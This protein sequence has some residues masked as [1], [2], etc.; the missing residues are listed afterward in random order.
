MEHAHHLYSQSS[1]VPPLH[2]SH[3]NLKLNLDPLAGHHP[4]HPRI[5]SETT[6]PATPHPRRTPPT[7]RSVQQATAN[8]R[9]PSGDQ[10]QNRE[11]G[12]PG[13]EGKDAAGGVSD[14]GKQEDN[15]R[16]PGQKA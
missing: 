6:T 15:T 9:H 3:S 16:S 8:T 12:L 2:S 14:D 10:E 13:A 7:R 11:Y 1:E 5:L 4:A